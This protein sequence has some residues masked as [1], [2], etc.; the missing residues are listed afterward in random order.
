MVLL[1]NITLCG[2]ESA[3]VTVALDAIRRN[4]RKH[5]MLSETGLLS[6]ALLSSHPCFRVSGGCMMPF[7]QQAKIASIRI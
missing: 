4:I 6:S 5:C 1:E 7:E 3:T 2:E